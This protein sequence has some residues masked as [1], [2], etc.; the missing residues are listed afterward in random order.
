MKNG[1]L[2]CLKNFW[3]IFCIVAI[4]I[5]GLIGGIAMIITISVH[6]INP[7]SAILLS[8]F[9]GVCIVIP[10]LLYLIFKDPLST[11]IFSEEGIEQKR[12]GKR[13][14]FIPWEKV[15]E[16]QVGRGEDRF[17]IYDEP[18]Y[19][20]HSKES[21]ISVILGGIPKVFPDLIDLCT[22]Q[23]I[24]SVLKERQHFYWKHKNEAN[25]P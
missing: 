25:R 21:K 9:L 2:K 3:F 10:W 20:F 23:K 16:L 17:V 19:V 5:A 8:L 15:K 11:V 6:G 1:Q 4:N 18:F 24:K 7:D 12:F 14:K 13:I 22:N